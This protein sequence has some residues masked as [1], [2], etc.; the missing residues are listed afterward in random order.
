MSIK[1]L[2]IGIEIEV[3][4]CAKNIKDQCKS[5]SED[6]AQSLVDY[7]NSKV[8]GTAGLAEMRYVLDLF[9][10]GDDPKYFTY[11][12]LKED[13]S[14]GLTEGHYKLLRPPSLRPCEEILAPSPSRANAY[15]ARG[16]RICITHFTLRIH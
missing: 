3:L 7:Y 5:S 15:C 8:C 14:I 6:F 16:F 11:W 9:R 4:L 10:A 12:S 2:R 1:A 13:G